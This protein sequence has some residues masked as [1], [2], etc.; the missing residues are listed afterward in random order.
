MLVRRGEHADVKSSRLNQDIFKILMGMMVSHELG[1][2][3]SFSARF[4]DQFF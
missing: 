1:K 2:I 4:Y 3:T